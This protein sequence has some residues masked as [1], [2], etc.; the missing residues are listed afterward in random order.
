MLKAEETNTLQA[1]RSG[2]HEAFNQ[3]TEPY[4]REIV[5][6]CYRLMGCTED[7]EDLLQETLLRAWRKL[8]TFVREVS[9]RAW[10]Y[11]IATNTCLN[12]LAKRPRRSLPENAYPPSD[13]LLPL[14]S[15]ISE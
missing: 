3:L 1:A 4:R 5:A 15:P 13:P 14:P 2:D 6:H 10:L 12:A 7:A 9:F 8:D 11:K